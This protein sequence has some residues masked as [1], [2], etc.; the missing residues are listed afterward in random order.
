MNNKLLQACACAL[1]VAVVSACGKS[2]NNNR[3]QASVDLQKIRDAEAQAAEKN[4]K[5]AERPGQDPAD[6][7]E[8]KRSG[9][10]G[11]ETLVWKRYRAFE[12]ALVNGLSLNKDQVC[13]ELGQSSCIDTIHLTVLGGNEPYVNAQYER[14]AA[15]SILTSVAIERVALAA[16]DQRLKLDQ[17]AGSAAVVFKHWSMSDQKVSQ[18]QIEAQARDLYR[19]LLARDPDKAELAASRE[20]L[21]LKLSPEKTALGLCFAIAS[22]AENIF[23]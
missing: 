3:Q 1:L 19:R 7:E 21:D 9:K 16:C 12:S 17:D 5:G 23:L 11:A 18:A 14:A 22:Q 8:A 13:K 20:I 15:P 10:S 4:G 2:K 6:D